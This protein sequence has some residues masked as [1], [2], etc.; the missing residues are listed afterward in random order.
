MKQQNLRPFVK[1]G[2]TGIVVLLLLGF[3]YNRYSE[4]RAADEQR[5]EKLEEEQQIEKAKRTGGG[6]EDGP[7]TQ[8]SQH[9]TEEPKTAKDLYEDD[10]L[11][12]TQE[13]GKEFASVLYEIDGDE[14]LGNLEGA[15]EFTTDNLKGMLESLDRQP[16]AINGNSRFYSRELKSIEMRE[17]ERVTDEFIIWEAHI[18]GEYFDR[19]GE[20][21]AD[22][23]TVYTLR[24]EKVGDEFK[25]SEF[26]VHPDY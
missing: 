20:K 19:S 7:G 14:P 12:E 23:E 18:T 10:E 21:T 25:V 22:D 24:F 26:N 6:S 9:E 11:N 1:I 8:G 15:T 4:Q 3:F 17:P 5:E 13:L 16:D 2:V